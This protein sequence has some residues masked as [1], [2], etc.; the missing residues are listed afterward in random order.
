MCLGRQR[1]KK[2][3]ELKPV[4]ARCSVAH[5]TCA[6]PSA[7]EV[8]H[9][10]RHKHSLP[11]SG[12]SHKTAESPHSTVSKFS[13]HAADSWFVPNATDGVSDFELQGFMDLMIDWAPETIPK[14]SYFPFHTF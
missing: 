7:E 9:D 14:V 6:W 8:A 2:C 13:P 5:L 3:D 4:C 12:S 11:S 1:K 10:G